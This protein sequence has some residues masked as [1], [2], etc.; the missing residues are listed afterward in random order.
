MNEQQVETREEPRAV[1][2]YQQTPNAALSFS[3]SDGFAL[4]QRQAIALSKSDLVPTV[5]KGKVENVLIA[6]ELATRIGAS[7]FAVMQNLYI[8][9]GKP[10]WYSQFI[11]SAVNA[12]GRLRGMMRFKIT[13]DGDAKT[14]IA[15]GTDRDTG[16]T[17][18][19]PPVSIGM[20]KAEGWF[21]KD[22]SKWKTMPELMLRYRAAAFFGRLYVPDIL[23]GMHSVDE[24]QDE[25]EVTPSPAL[26]AGNGNGAIKSKA[27][28][29]GAELKARAE[30][31][32]EPSTSDKSREIIAAA[33]LNA[34][35]MMPDG[36]QFRYIL[37]ERNDVIVD[38]QTGE[39]FSLAQEAQKTEKVAQEAAD[40][41]K[42]GKKD[43]EE[44]PPYPADWPERRKNEKPKG[45]DMKW[46]EKDK[47]TPKFL[48]KLIAQKVIEATYEKNYRAANE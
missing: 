47:A 6:L 39:T 4:A 42:T 41:A 12:S 23:M 10:A 14:C 28:S 16:E 9:H 34:N 37:G 46:S 38:Q 29:L 35:E 32:A 25:I 43:D 3:T 30:K 26:T 2:Q 20:A 17:L 13:G 48:D 40:A 36:F 27:A 19:S 1:L 18:E 5:F 15:Y 7:P 21:T 33:G 8:V 22:G 24:V 45:F 11:I 31:K 44:A